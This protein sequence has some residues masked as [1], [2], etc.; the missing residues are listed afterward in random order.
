MFETLPVPK[1]RQRQ[2]SSDTS[3]SERSDSLVQSFSLIQ[4]S[5]LKRSFLFVLTSS[6]QT[7]GVK[8]QKPSDRRSRV[9]GEV[10]TNIVHNP[11]K[12]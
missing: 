9:V 6:N 1:T 7:L 4:I 3:S 8:S 10:L 2:R 5:N 11:E 12:K